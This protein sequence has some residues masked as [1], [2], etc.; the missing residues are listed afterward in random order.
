MKVLLFGNVGSGKTT[1]L[2]K[3]KDLFSFDAIAIDDYR[4]KYSD[5]SNGGEFNAK[6]FFLKAIQPGKNQFIECIGVG[7]V[8]DDLFELLN[9]SNERV[10]CLTI[11]TP[12][13]I[14]KS[15]LENRIWDIPF[16]EPLEKVSALLEKT[17]LKIQE[18]VIE[19]KWD[20]R[21]NS[22]IISRNNITSGDVDIIAEEMS[23]LIKDTL[24]DFEIMLNN[25]IQSYYGNEYLTYQKSIIE[26]NDKFLQDR[27]MISRFIKKSNVTGNIID[28]GSGS[29]QWFQFFEKDISLYYAVETNS[30]S[31]SFAPQ[32]EKLIP[33][34]KNI[35]D[36]EFNL[37]MAINAE[38]DYAFFSFFLSHF[39]DNTIHKLFTKLQTINSLMIVDSF[40]SSDHKI[41]YIAKD[42]RYITRKLPGKEIQLPKRFF[43]FSDLEK[44]AQAFGFKIT[45]FEQGNYWFACAMK[46][47]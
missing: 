45:N 46:K 22:I 33:I 27:L 30:T 6:K 41:K 38:I 2:T 23:I 14:C 4:R 36:N 19:R 34:N 12:K 25:E 8:G 29:C 40:W 31:L 5:G 17:E 18:R 43:E 16:P 24:N 47:K 21:N 35:F 11:L 1:L 28:I 9:N 44:L 3:L 10:I 42:L 39:S 7:S 26:K 20:K 15:R 13:E 32:N 37:R